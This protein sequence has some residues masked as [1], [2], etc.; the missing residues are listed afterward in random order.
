M[1]L[2]GLLVAAL[3]LGLAGC[4]LCERWN[5]IDDG[6]RR[7]L[8]G[9]HIVM[10]DDPRLPALEKSY[11]DVDAEM[12]GLCAQPKPSKLAIAQTTLRGVAIVAGLVMELRSHPV[13]HGMTLPDIDLAKLEKDLAKA[14]ADAEKELAK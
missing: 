4:W 10:P 9:L 12:R 8:A 3:A 13:P 5:S 6:A 11:I 14:K 7:V 2:K 1:K